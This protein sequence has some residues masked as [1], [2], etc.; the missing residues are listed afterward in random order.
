MHRCK[1][2]VDL[3]PTSPH[4]P[5][6]SATHSLLLHLTSHEATPGPRPEHAVGNNC[7]RIV[8]CQLMR[9]C[10]I[11]SAHKKCNVLLV[12][13][14]VL[15]AGS[16]LRRLLLEIQ[17]PCGGPSGSCVREGKLKTN[18]LPR[19]N[20]WYK[21]R[22][23]NYIASSCP[24]AKDVSSSYTSELTHLCEMYDASASS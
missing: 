18:Q 6:G 16:L 17:L 12:D 8:S 2:L 14:V 9:Y 15:R 5:H 13:V 22:K 10:I 23:G 7:N 24:R 11:H 1:L 3:L 4:A 20:S 21:N 19:S